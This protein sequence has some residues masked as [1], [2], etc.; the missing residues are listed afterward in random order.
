MHAAFQHYSLFQPSRLL[1]LFLPSTILWL[2]A[3]FLRTCSWFGM[4]HYWSVCCSSSK[5]FP[6]NVGA[7]EAIYTLILQKWCFPRFY[8]HYPPRQIFD[9]VCHRTPGQQGFV[10]YL[11]MYSCFLGMRPLMNWLWLIMH[12]FV[13]FFCSDITYNILFEA[14]TT[15]LVFFSYQLFHKEILRNGIIYQHI[16]KGRW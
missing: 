14:V 1:S 5:S 11:W 9:A 2:L 4:E 7:Q 3:H 10:L 6:I 16:M 8:S 15:L 13:C 12:L